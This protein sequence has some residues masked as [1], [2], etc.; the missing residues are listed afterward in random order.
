ME[1]VVIAVGDV[2]FVLLV[3]GLVHVQLGLEIVSIDNAISHI[4]EY[5]SV[6]DFVNS[7]LAKLPPSILPAKTWCPLTLLVHL[8]R[9]TPLFASART[10]GP[11]VLSRRII[12]HS[13]CVNTHLC[14]SRQYSNS[15][16]LPWGPGSRA[17]KR[18]HF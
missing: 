17:K 9:A 3:G 2:V 13:S 11:S 6:H 1:L 18:S 16:I 14:S 15:A 12:K 10:A 5:S 4:C 8:H 7:N